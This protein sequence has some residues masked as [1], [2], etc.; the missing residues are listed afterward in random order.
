V[1]DGQ[2]NDCDGLTDEG[3]PGGGVACSTGQQ[4]VC[5]AGTRQCLGGVLACIRDVPPAAETC[6]GL[7]DD[8]DGTTD[9]GTAGGSCSTGLPGVC[10]AGTRECTGGVLLC[11]PTASAPE[12]CDD[13]DNDCD[14]VVDG[15]DPGGGAACS[16]GEGGV[17][18]AGIE[19]CQGG[20]LACVRTTAPSS[21]LCGTALDED[22]NG[23]TDEAGC[24]YCLPADSVT[25][26]TQTKKTSAKLSVIPARDGVQTKGTFTLPGGV[27]FAPDVAQVALRLTDGSGTTWY[28]V[29]LPAGSFVASGSRR[30]FK[31]SDRT[32]ALAGLKSAKFSLVSLGTVKYAFKAKGRDQPPFVT[33]AGSALIRV[34]SRCFV[35]T[36]D[37]CIVSPSGS[38]VRCE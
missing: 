19:H 2:D 11:T 34:G 22:C 30:S 8:C 17:C 33:G 24:V 31:F 27:T 15:G 38:S 10:N 12:V 4:G 29:V 36:V 7:D 26:A 14:G 37:T 9:E 16:T 5:A 18:A 21:E 23:Q 28:E 35:D 3:N 25:L 32:L 6:N 20:S 13:Q 1:C